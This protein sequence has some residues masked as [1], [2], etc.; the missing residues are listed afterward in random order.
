MVVYYVEENRI[1]VVHI[2]KA[3]K[4]Y[5]KAYKDYKLGMRY[6]DIAKKYNTTENTVNCWK[7]LHFNKFAEEEQAEKERRDAEAAHYNAHHLN[8]MQAAEL[9]QAAQEPKEDR[10]G[11]NSIQ[12][13]Q[14]MQALRELVEVKRS[15]APP[16]FKAT[17]TGKMLNRIGQYFQ[18]QEDNGKPYTRAGIILALGICRSTYDRYLKGEMDYLIEEHI[19]IN[20][21]DI[22]ACSRIQLEDGSEIPVDGAGNPLIPFSQILQK[23]LLKLE[24][25]AE[26]RLYGKAR[27]G[28]IFT[29]KQYGWTDER[30]PG[31]VNNTLVIAT[32]E[33]SDRALKMLYGNS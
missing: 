20:Q 1:K 6:V 28:D 2:T 19:L 25:Q 3:M 17:D 11:Q 12:D 14:N 26:S 15:S 9:I 5:E 10:R 8:S 13:S 30:S 33:E 21:I 18:Q 32:A 27:P 16:A 31:T 22:E 29:M 7:R 4:N 23:A 24:E